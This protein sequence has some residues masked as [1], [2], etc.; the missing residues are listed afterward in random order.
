MGF[1]LNGWLGGRLKSRNF[2]EIMI[3]VIETVVFIL[4]DIITIIV[5]LLRIL[6]S[7]L[8]TLSMTI[9]MRKNDLE[10]WK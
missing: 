2:R 9:V 6:L 10:K 3:D 8:L 7:L 1:A 4:N 5:I